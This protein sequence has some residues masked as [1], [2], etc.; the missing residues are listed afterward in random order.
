MLVDALATDLDLNVLD[1]DVANPVQPTE[2][3]GRRHGDGGQPDTQVHLLDQVTVTA[4][5]ASH[6]L[7]EAGAAVEGLLDGLGAVVGVTAVYAEP[8][9]SLA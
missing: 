9:L 2:L 7:A 1:Q 5:G 6:L 4:D 8:P 3:L